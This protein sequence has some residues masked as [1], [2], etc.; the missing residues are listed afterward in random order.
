M[1][2]L[3]SWPCENKRECRI[4]SLCAW[5][6]NR[7]SLWIPLCVLLSVCL[8]KRFAKGRSGV[9]SGKPGL[10]RNEQKIYNGVSRL[11]AHVIR[12]SAISTA[13][14]I[15]ALRTRVDCSWKVSEFTCYLSIF[16]LG[17]PL[18]K[19]NRILILYT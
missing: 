11:T 13:G 4:I 9:K 16:I 10:H 7:F 5:L 12:T 3:S 18:L 8:P 2:Q 6:G 17:R 19:W 15:A 14:N 1:S